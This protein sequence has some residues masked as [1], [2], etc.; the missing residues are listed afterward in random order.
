MIETPVE[1]VIFENKDLFQL[2]SREQARDG[3]AFEVPRAA[4]N[5]RPYFPAIGYSPVRRLSFR[6]IATAHK[7]PTP[8]NGSKYTSKSQRP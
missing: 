2:A 4:A 6:T 1:P 8:R 5:F 3:R 7:I